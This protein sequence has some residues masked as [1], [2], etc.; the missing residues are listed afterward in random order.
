MV[1]PDYLLDT[2]VSEGQTNWSIR[3]HSQDGSEAN[4]E[5]M[6]VEVITSQCPQAARTTVYKMLSAIAP[7]C[8][9]SVYAALTMLQEPVPHH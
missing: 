7:V 5:K 6:M 1:A 3:V 8:L 9:L 2:Q 4:A